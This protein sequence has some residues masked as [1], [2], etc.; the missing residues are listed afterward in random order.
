VGFL[1]LAGGGGK[2]TVGVLASYSQADCFQC[3]FYRFAAGLWV[4][5]LCDSDDPIQI[6]K[7]VSVL[8]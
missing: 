1:L 6:L 3:N 5:L 4:F 7:K 8:I 2:K